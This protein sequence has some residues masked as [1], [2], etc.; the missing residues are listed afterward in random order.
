[1]MVNPDVDGYTKTLNH[2]KI[3]RKM[4]KK[5]NENQT[6]TKTE[7]DFYIYCSLMEWQF[8]P[9]TAAG[10]P[11]HSEKFP[12]TICEEWKKFEIPNTFL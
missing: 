4:Q 1:M 5:I 12:L 9:P 3:L 11:K 7:A 2:Q 10:R 6:N 8:A